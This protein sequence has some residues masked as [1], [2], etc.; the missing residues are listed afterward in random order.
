MFISS[1]T[2]F[3]PPPTLHKCLISNFF[4]PF[5]C[6][7]VAQVL[8]VSKNFLIWKLY[9]WRSMRSCNHDCPPASLF[10]NNIS[11]AAIFS[12]QLSSLT[13]GT[14]FLTPDWNFYGSSLFLLK[15]RNQ[16]VD[17][18]SN[19]GLTDAVIIFLI[20]SKSMYFKKFW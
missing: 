15:W 3:H 1:L 19:L 4:F 20:F 7:P 13:S 18:Q 14:I 8:S 9:Y 5:L 6:P 2:L 12:L 16:T 10:Q 17:T 11:M